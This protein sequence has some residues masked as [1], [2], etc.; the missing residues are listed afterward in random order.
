MVNWLCKSNNWNEDGALKKLVEKAKVKY[1][2]L[3]EANADTREH[4]VHPITALQ[5]EYSLWT[6]EIE[7]IIPLCRFL[8]AITTS[9][10]YIVSFTIVLN[11]I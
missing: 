11:F 5:I 7:E 2:G 9:A 10:V 8:N 3:S 6:C 4:A 1:I